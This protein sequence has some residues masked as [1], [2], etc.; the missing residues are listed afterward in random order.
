[1]HALSRTF[2]LT[3]GFVLVSGC[4]TKPSEPPVVDRLRTTLVGVHEC[5]PHRDTSGPQTME[6]A[7]GILTD[8]G[9]HYA[10]DFN[11]MSQIPP[12]LAT[13]DRFSANGVLTP[14]EMISSDH[15]QKYDVQGIFTVTD[16]VEK[17]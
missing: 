3:T 2:L 7:L 6:C 1:M 13:G 12:E 9:R 8:D 15:W 4:A 14:I 17:L 16:S 11:L 5:L 10:L